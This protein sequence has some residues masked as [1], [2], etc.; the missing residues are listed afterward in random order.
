[1]K[2]SLYVWYDKVDK[3]Y[4]LSSATFSRS[5]RAM[6]RGYLHAFEQDKR[7]NPKEY[8]LRRIA[9]FDDETGEFLG[10]E[11]TK[12]DPMIVYEKIDTSDGQPHEE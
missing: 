2:Q 11:N 3:T 12:V 8:E 7:M 6:C 9:T 5:E 4:N 10:T 1:M